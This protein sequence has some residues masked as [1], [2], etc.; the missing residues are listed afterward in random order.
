MLNFSNSEMLNFTVVNF[1]DL[2]ISEIFSGNLFLLF[3][4]VGLSYYS[5]VSY[6]TFLNF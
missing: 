3:S 2:K 4:P 5:V 1:E 6:I